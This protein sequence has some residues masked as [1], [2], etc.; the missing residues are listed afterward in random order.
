VKV[1]RLERNAGAF[2]RNVGARH[3]STPYIAFCDDDTWWLPG[4]IERGADI[5]DAF[6]RVALLNARVTV[7]G[8]DRCDP[9]CERMAEALC[10]DGVPGVPITFFMAGS[11]MVRRESFLEAGGYEP[12]F[13]IGGEETLLSI[14]LLQNGWS[15]RYVPALKVRHDPCPVERNGATRRRLVIRNRLWTAWMRLAPMDALRVT[16]EVIAQATH[17][18]LFRYALIDAAN[19]FSWAIR[20]RKS[21]DRAS[22]AHIRSLW[23]R[24]A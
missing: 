18:R 12:R 2:A 23:G 21:I 1:V 19:G 8:E 5:L 24:E 13:L 20:H 6:P 22:S 3:A 9:A 15:M 11:C 7:N 4:S 14:D 10:D 17:D 16:A